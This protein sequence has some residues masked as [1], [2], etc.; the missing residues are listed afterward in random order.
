VTSDEEI[1]GCSFI[2]PE[3]M[4]RHSVCLSISHSVQ[5]SIFSCCQMQVENPNVA[6]DCL[7][8]VLRTDTRELLCIVHGYSVLYS[9]QSPEYID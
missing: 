4:H 5:I 2:G 6:G 3:P 1:A 9:G 7:R 8:L